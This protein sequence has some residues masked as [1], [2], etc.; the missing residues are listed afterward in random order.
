MVPLREFRYAPS[1]RGHVAYSS[2]PDVHNIII[3]S[4][5]NAIPVRPP[6]QSADL[7]RVALQDTNFMLGDTHVV[8]PDAPI[9]AAAAQDM[10]IPA[11]RRDACL[12]AAHRPQPSAS[13]DIPDFHLSIAQPNGNIRAIARPVERADIVPLCCLGEARDGPGLRV[14]DICVLRER[15][16]EDISRRPGEQ[17]EI[18]V[19][20]HTGRVENAFRLRGEAP[21]LR[22]RGTTAQRPTRAARRRLFARIIQR[23]YIGPLGVEGR[24]LRGRRGL[25]EGE[26]SRSGIDAHSFGESLNVRRG[27]FF[28]TG[29]WAG[30]ERSRLWIGLHNEPVRLRPLNE[31]GSQ[32]TNQTNNTTRRKERKRTRLEHDFVRFGLFPFGALGAASSADFADFCELESALAG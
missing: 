19:V 30:R 3:P 2:V 8:V 28:R 10:A 17:V 5:R 9:L 15:D 1:V 13:F 18:V 31:G 21:L 20:D 32:P 25:A 6:S 27:V 29:K 23:L 22:A 12:A 14:P 16:S 4:A 26:D 24:I 11:K 7:S